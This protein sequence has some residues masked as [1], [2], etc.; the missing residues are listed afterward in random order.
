MLGKRG[1]YPYRKSLP[2]SKRRRFTAPIQAA[3]TAAAA[4]AAA[5]GAPVAYRGYRANYGLPRSIYNRPEKK[6]RDFLLVMI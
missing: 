5:M 3:S 2:A 1:Y 4:T 6:Y